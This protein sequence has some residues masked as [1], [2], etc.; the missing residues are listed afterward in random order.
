M[1]SHAAIEP[2]G[3]ERERENEE[4]I[5][6]SL[7]CLLP[8]EVWCDFMGS[9]LRLGLLHLFAQIVL[10]RTTQITKSSPN[11]STHTDLYMKSNMANLEK[12]LACASTV[13]SLHC[14]IPQHNDNNN[15]GA[16]VQEIEYLLI[17]HRPSVISSCALVPPSI[18]WRT[19]TTYKK[20]KW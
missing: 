4:Q 12:P 15:C 17:M 6:T 2:G 19:R 20:V 13:S 16:N 14:T 8:F 3:E 1:A 9:G 11:P 7:S 18:E 10:T 5:A